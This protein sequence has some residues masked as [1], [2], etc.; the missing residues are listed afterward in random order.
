MYGDLTRLSW[1]K[2]VFTVFSAI[3][4]LISKIEK[5]TLTGTQKDTL[6]YQRRLWMTPRGI[7]TETLSGSL[8]TENFFRWDSSRGLPVGLG[9][10]KGRT[11]P[12]PPNTNP[13]SRLFGL[14]DYST[15]AGIKV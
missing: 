13:V 1:P 8:D 14:A 10:F 4:G 15:G 5:Q 2:S 7:I 9:H 11:N 3:D 6:R 12:E